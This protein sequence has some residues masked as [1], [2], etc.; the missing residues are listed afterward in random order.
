MIS[1]KICRRRKDGNLLKRLPDCPTDQNPNPNLELCDD[2]D[3]SRLLLEHAGADQASR[4]LNG[5][6]TDSQEI[7]VDNTRKR[8]SSEILSEIQQENQRLKEARTCKICMDNEIEV[9]L[10]PCGHTHYWKCQLA[11]NKE[12]LIPPIWDC[13][14]PTEGSFFTHGQIKNPAF[15]EGR[16]YTG[17]MIRQMWAESAVC[18]N[19]YL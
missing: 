10:Y 13:C 11:K 9:A 6:V 7:K 12:L 18:L 5:T 1:K 4:E 15:F 3:P 16:C 2:I 8:K 19:S 17:K 14:G